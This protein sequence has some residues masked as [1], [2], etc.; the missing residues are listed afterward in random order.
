MEHN[1]AAIAEH[2]HSDDGA[3]KE[4]WKVTLILSVLTIIELVLGFWMMGMPD[5]ALRYSIKGSI[6]ILML[7][8]AFYIVGY[9]MHL[10]HE[11]RNLIMTIVVPLLLFIWFIVAFLYE[12]NSYKNLKNTY[13]SYYKE[14]TSQQQETKEETKEEKGEEP[15]KSDA[16]E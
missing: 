3:V 7:A 14:R 8:K 11:V 6:V 16:A 2:G 1:S 9:F 12:G 4:I 10:K 13:N 15:K 5:G